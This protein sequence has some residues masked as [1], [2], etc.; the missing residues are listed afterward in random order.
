MKPIKECIIITE[1]QFMGMFSGQDVWL[2]P[3]EW[4]EENEEEIP[5][6]IGVKLDFDRAYVG[7]DWIIQNNCC[8]GY[9]N[10]ECAI[11]VEPEQMMWKTAPEYASQ[12]SEK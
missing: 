11:A 3:L 1:T 5:N 6:T 12:E 4:I 9:N 2:I 8:F 7:D 10:E